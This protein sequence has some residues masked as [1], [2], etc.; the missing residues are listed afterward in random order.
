MTTENISYYKSGPR[1]GQVWV[2][3]GKKP[4]VNQYKDVYDYILENIDAS[5]YDKNP[6]TPQEKL[7]FLRDTFRAEYGWHIKR[8]GEFR[9]MTEWLQ[10]VPS[11][12]H[13]DFWNCDI[14]VLS[15]KW[16]RL[17]ANPTEKQQDIIIESWFR[18]IAMR[19]GELMRKY[20]IKESEVQL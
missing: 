10:G 3:K 17:P 4:P 2:K 20:K 18:F 13:I 8:M 11:S 9:A 19:I 14:V 5:G 6:V 15:K 7:Q 1:K 12:I 16:G